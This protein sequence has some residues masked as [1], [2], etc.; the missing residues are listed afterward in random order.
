MN[1]R[2]NG[3]LPLFSLGQVVSTPGALEA[4]AE[5]DES[6]EQLLRRHVSG[7]WGVLCVEDQQENARAL[8][9]GWRIL[10]AYVL[11]T[12]VKIWVITEA[13]RSVTT[14]LLPSEY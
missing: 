11:S 13:D 3:R 9:N 2:T 7:D 8:A 4:V 6:F 12:G 1:N 14:I 10:S 5:A